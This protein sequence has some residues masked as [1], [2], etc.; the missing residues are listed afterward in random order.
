MLSNNTAVTATDMLNYLV[1]WL[2]GRRIL[3]RAGVAASA[4]GLM[5]LGHP[6]FDLLAVG[7]IG[8]ALG[9]VSFLS[10]LDVKQAAW[11]GFWCGLGFFVVLLH[12]LVEPFLV[13]PEQDGWMAPFALFFLSGGLALFWAAAFAIARRFGSLV[14]LCLALTVAEGLRSYVL[15][16]FPWGL[17]GYVWLNSPVAQ[18]G[19]WIGPHGLNLLTLVL[20]FLPLSALSKNRSWMAL[21]ALLGVG[22]GALVLGHS[23]SQSAVPSITEKTLRLIQPNA[24]QDQKWR[25]ENRA[26][27]FELQLGFTRQKPQ[28]DLIVWPE[29]AIPVLLNEADD[30]VAQIA[31]AAN[32]ATVVLGAQ[33]HDARGYYNTLAVLNP[34]GQITQR[35]DKHHLVP[36]GEYIPFLGLFGVVGKGFAAQFGEGYQAGSGPTVLTVEG[37]GKFLPLICYE[38]VF[39]HEVGAVSQRADFMLQITNDAWFGTFSGPYQHLAQARMRAIEQGLPLVRAANTGVSAVID[40]KGNLLQHLPLGQA[41]YLDVRLPGPAAPTFYSHFGDWPVFLLLSLLAGGGILG[42]RYFGD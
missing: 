24:A 35:Y 12:W 42:R 4:G 1:F 41:G 2:S 39:P 27:F 23:A 31:A 8:L 20:V 9:G 17:I 34:Q 16:G 25:L 11:T 7:L 37:V 14:V 13:Y 3:A 6:P 18:L 29:T 28:P 10:A 15:T 36:F 33:R 22:L 19:A 30:V 38:L 26:L 5:A 21:A 40:S 32:G